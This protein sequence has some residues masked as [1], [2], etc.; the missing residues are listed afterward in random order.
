[1]TTRFNKLAF[2]AAAA[3]F[4][5][6]AGATGA[7]AAPA[8]AD[9]QAKARVL[10]QL[11]IVKNTDLNFGTIVGGPAASTVAVSASGAVTCGTG[12]TCT[13]T[14]TGAKFTVVG[15]KNEIV[16]VTMPASV[17]LTNGTGG[18]MTATLDRVTTLNL[19]TTANTGTALSFGGTIAVA[20]AQADGIYASPNFTVTVDYQ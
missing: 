20:A 2:A 1:M 17:V 11:T 12:V 6:G 15:T 3:L 16:N 13:G 9:A 4:A 7:S 5:L 19:G 8:S 10:Q 18:L 14:A